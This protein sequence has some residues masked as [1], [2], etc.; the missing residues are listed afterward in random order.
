MTRKLKVL[1][2]VRDARLRQRDVTAAETSL[3]EALERDAELQR[4]QARHDLEMLYEHATARLERASD[5]RHLLELESERY[6]LG[7]RVEEA[8]KAYEAAVVRG[9]HARQVLRDHERALR[10]S[11]KVIER[12]QSGLDQTERRDEQRTSDD[13]VGGRR[14]A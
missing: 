3:V 11:E 4:D 14:T 13:F 10:T 9:N 2:R 12:E 8:R 6:A 7:A 1:G 5:V